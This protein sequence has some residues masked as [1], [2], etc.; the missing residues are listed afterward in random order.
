MVKGPAGYGRN[1]FS[2]WREI[3]L[4]FHLKVSPFFELARMQIKLK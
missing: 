3:S 4:S 1:P 2:I